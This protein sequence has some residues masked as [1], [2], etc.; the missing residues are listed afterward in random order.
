MPYLLRSGAIPRLSLAVLGLTATACS[1]HHQPL[2][3]ADPRVSEPIGWYDLGP[4]HKVLVTWAPAGDDLRLLDFDSTRFAALSNSGDTAFIWRRGGDAPERLVTFPRDEA[5]AVSGLRWASAD[6]DGFFPR[7]QEFPF[8]QEQLSFRNDSIE[9]AALL[10][11]PRVR[12]F[13]GEPRLGMEEVAVVVPGAVVIHGSGSS[14][15]DNVWAFH[16]AQHLASN[17]VAVVLPDK[18]GSGGSGGDWRTA[19]FNDLAD[20]ALAAAEVLARN[21]KV[22][23]DRIGFVGLS[24]GGWIA[25]LAATRRPGTGFVI[26][27]SGAAVTP[28]NQVRHE[29]EQDLLRAG[30]SDD[31][32]AAVLELLAAAD[33]YSRTLSDADWTPYIGLRQRLLR[34]PFAEAIEPFPDTREHWRWQWWHRIIDFDPLPHWRR[35][36]A[37]ALVVYGAQ[38]EHDNVPVEESVEVLRTALRPHRAPANQI[39]VFPESGHAL[40]DPR[41][42]WIRGDFLKLLSDWL[43]EHVGEER[44]REQDG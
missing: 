10:M 23:P 16:I 43:S 4:G 18:R 31:A 20:D 24:Q 22:D 5:G 28:G 15:R 14:D 30:L 6:G 34:E 44:D 29:V 21:P 32:V 39:R 3:W 35:F 17:G 7:A 37:P 40:G 38:D 36:D 25:P 33:R 12:K 2:K 11:V 8:D 1:A 27:V 26:N 42:G 13:V 41:T 19:D 9:L